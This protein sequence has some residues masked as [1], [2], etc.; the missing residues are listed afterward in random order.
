MIVWGRERDGDGGKREREIYFSRGKEI[1]EGLEKRG[2]IGTTV[3]K[4]A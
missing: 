2:Q 3:E 1:G 4:L